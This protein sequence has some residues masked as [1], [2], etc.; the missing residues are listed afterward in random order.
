MSVHSKSGDY[1]LVLISWIRIDPPLAVEWPAFE[2]DHTDCG[3][4]GCTVEKPSQLKADPH[5]LNAVSVLIVSGIR[6]QLVYER[7]SCA[8]NRSSSST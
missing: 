4:V 2:Q 3:H 1:P 5:F 6:L 8:T 7:T